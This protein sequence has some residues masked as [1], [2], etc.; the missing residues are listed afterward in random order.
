MYRVL[1]V[2]D[3]PHICS[4]VARAL[5]QLEIEVNTAPSGESALAAIAAEQPNL[6]LT[7]M[8]MPGMSGLD[9]LRLLHERAPDLLVIM[10]TAHDDL[11][12]IA[13]AMGAGAVDFLTK[14]LDLHNLREVIRRV[15]EDSRARARRGSSESHPQGAVVGRDPR[16]VEVFKRIGQVAGTRTTVLIRGESGT[17]KELIA[18][19]VHH[20]SPYRD[21]PFVAV[22]CAALPTTLLESELFG[23]I[24]GAFTGAA[25]DRQ[26]RFA[27]AGRGT[28]FLDEI[29]DTSQDFQTKLLRV[30]QEREYYPVGGDR[31]QRT[32]ARVI[33][34]THRDLEALVASG[35][36]RADLYYRLRVVELR[37]PPLRERRGDLPLLAEQ[38]VHRAS[39][40][41]R[42]RPPVLSREAMDAL[43]RHTWP[44][45]IRELENCLMRAVVTAG[46]VI[47]PEHLLLEIPRAAPQPAR[48]EKLSRV[49]CDHV[50]QVL[51]AMGGHKTRTARILGI[52]RPRLDRLLQKYG[53]EPELPDG[54]G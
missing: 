28:I 27:Q 50:A 54:A 14:P 1:V 49:E 5:V 19:A 45:N 6:V 52:S 30:L 29:G 22:N 48:L 9:L 21:E 20:H 39:E 33:A 51:S 24:R 12:L 4:A 16:I 41:V 13:T 44:G 26:G 18:R 8:R 40:S 25:A 36:F 46:E 17:G 38:L 53:I 11:P 15:L 37:I 47:R 10:M 3:D 35:D 23:H 43:M 42:R 31:P 34:A 7:D 32:E 2:D